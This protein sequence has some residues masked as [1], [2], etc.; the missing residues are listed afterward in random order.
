MYI[1]TGGAGFIGSAFVWELNKQGIEDILI[2]DN[3]GYGEKWKNLTG[4]KFIDYEHRD[5]LFDLLEKGRLP[6][7]KGIIHMGACSSTTERDAEFLMRNNFHYSQD[8]ALFCVSKGVRFIYAS[9]AATYGDGQSGFDDSHAALDLYRPLNMYGYSK[10]LFDLWAWKKNLLSQMAGLKFFNVFGPNE[11]HKEDM[12][13][14]ICKAYSQIKETGGL[15]LF[16]SYHEDYPHGGQMRDFIY[17]KDCTAVMYWLLENKEV[18]GVFNLGTGTPRTWNDLARAVF[19]AMGREPRIEYIQMPESLRP[20]YQY[21]TRAQMEK[22]QAV[23]CP[24]NFTSL[25]DGARDYVQNYL[26][27]PDPYLDS[28]RS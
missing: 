4:L 6:A 26:A 10:H 1:V 20:K 17:V 18:N 19:T 23:G 5:R 14:V 8:L 22:L 27:A 21:Y 15:K 9:S 13:S 28:S 3:L 16:R 11:Y 25:E 12:K 7:V 24:L 2:V